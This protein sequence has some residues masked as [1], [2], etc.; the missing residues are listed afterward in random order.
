MGPWFRLSSM[1]SIVPNVSVVT[2]L[3]PC[4]SEANL[5]GER[6]LK[7]AQKIGTLQSDDR[8]GSV[9]VKKAIP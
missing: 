4:G 2:K 1:T 3:F 7:T 8:D 9:N 5:N 6:D